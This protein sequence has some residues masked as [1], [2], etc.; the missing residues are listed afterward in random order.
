MAS[1]HQP[2]MIKLLTSDWHP[3]RQQT[4]ESETLEV[5][6][7]LQNPVGVSAPSA[8]LPVTKAAFL[9]AV[10]LMFMLDSAAGNLQNMCST[11]YPAVPC[12]Y[13]INNEDWFRMGDRYCVKAFYHTKHLPFYE[14]E[15]VCNGYKHSNR[16]GHLVSIHNEKEHNDLICTMYRV[17]T[18]KPHY[19]IGMHRAPIDDYDFGLVWIDGSKGAY[20][21]WAPRQPDFFLWREGCVEMNYWDWGLL[22]DEM[23]SQHRPYVCAVQIN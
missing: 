5:V 9:S 6:L 7:Q 13:K 19:W 21:R 11:Q 8:M 23:C 17:H 2:F 3:S 12:P 22:N 4:N 10:V 15:K 18:G 14:A 20:L 16:Q 1:G